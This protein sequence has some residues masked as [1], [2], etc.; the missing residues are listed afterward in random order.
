MRE[1]F[2][3][4]TAWRSS[5]VKGGNCS[6]NMLGNSRNRARSPSRRWSNSVKSRAVLDTLVLLAHSAVLFMLVE[7]WFAG[8]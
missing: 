1:V 2:C 6:L 5:W 8:L 4:T 7:I 3:S